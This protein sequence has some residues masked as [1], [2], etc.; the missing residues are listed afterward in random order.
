MLLAIPGDDDSYAPA[1]TNRPADT[2]NTA[3][4][5]TPTL[6]LQ[7]ERQQERQQQTRCSGQ[8]VSTK[9]LAQLEERRAELDAG[10]AELDAQEVI[11]H[12]VDVDWPRPHRA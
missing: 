1:N 9:R 5:T 2:I 7:Q 12:R 3:K 8:A 4:T 11:A 6:T 10:E